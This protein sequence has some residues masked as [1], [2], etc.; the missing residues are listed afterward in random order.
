M[1]KFS[2][3]FLCFA[4]SLLLLA[5]KASATVMVTDLNILYVLGAQEVD[6]ASQSSEFDAVSSLTDPYGGTISFSPTVQHRVVGSSW[7]TWP[8]TYGD[9][10]GLDVLMA[11]A[12]SLTLDFAP[13]AIT[14]F[15]FELE[16]NVFA[17]FE[18]MLTLDDGSTQTQFVDG[19]TGAL[20]FGF[21]GGHVSS[22][23]ITD[24]SGGAGGF[25]IGRL[26][27]TQPV[28]EPATMLL[29][30]SGLIGMFGF[31]KR[32]KNKA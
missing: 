24:V 3:I 13:D 12:T 30:G 20:T 8:S 28:P 5:G 10:A 18:M 11:S 15:G 21:I 26:T 9:P 16:P 7:A 25:S 14:G 32:K 22:L 29:L 2:K 19:D 6:I 1:K 4:A 27:M 23:T 31:K 17:T